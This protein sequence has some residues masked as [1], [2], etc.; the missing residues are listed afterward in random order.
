MLVG[1]AGVAAEEA[2]RVLLSIGRAEFTEPRKVLLAGLLWKKTTMSQPW[3]AEHLGMKNADNAN[4]VIRRIDLSRIQKKVPE[5]LR[6]FVSE[7][8][9]PDLQFSNF[10]CFYL[11]DQVWAD[12]ICT[13]LL[14]LAQQK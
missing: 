14:R 4:R 8:M 10:P 6:S 11:R 5:T 3:I 9:N 7:K 1:F 2:L 13:G 12:F